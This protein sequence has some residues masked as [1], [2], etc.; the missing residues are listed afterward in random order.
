MKRLFALLTLSSFVAPLGALAR[1]YV[2]TYEQQC[3]RDEYT[4]TYI[5]GTRRNP[6]YVRVDVERVE[7]PCRRNRLNTTNIQPY[8]PYAPDYR[9]TGPVDDNSCIEGSIIGGIL[10]GAAV[11]AGSR[12]PDMAW[13]IPLGVVGGSLVGCQIDGG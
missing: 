4:E 11:A 10:G 5:P 9:P 3:W 1:P 8:D 7:V 13:A 6:G 12:G 2:G